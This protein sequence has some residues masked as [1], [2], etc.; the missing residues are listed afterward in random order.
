MTALQKYFPLIKSREE[1][2][3]TIQ[4]NKGLNGIYCEWKKEQQEEFSRFL[5][6]SKR[7]KTSL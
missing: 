5:Y 6:R 7:S 1:L 4:E 2:V 3:K